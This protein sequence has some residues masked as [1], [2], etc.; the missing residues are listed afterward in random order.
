MMPYA[1]PADKAAWMRKYQ[2]EYRAGKR[3]GQNPTIRADIAEA[4]EARHGRHADG[5]DTRAAHVALMREMGV[6]AT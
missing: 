2:P 5:L 1:N 4:I 6:G 3:R